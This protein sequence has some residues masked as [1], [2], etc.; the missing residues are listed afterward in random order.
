MTEKAFQ[1]S[2]PSDVI[3]LMYDRQHT[4]I[5]IN[6][7]HHGNI[8]KKYYNPRREVDE[9]STNHLFRDE[10]IVGFFFALALRVSLGRYW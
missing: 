5:I 2:N 10:I 9:R 6:C 1:S 4:Y 3:K 7:S 8:N